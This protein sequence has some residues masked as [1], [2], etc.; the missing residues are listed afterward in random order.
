MKRW[1][2]EAKLL[3]DTVLSPTTAFEAVELRAP[4]GAPLLV[5]G[6]ATSLLLLVQG[7]VLEQ[8]VRL[9]PLS[10]ETPGGAEVAIRAF[11]IVRGAAALGAPFGLALRAAALASVLQ[12]TAM[13]LGARSAWRSLLSLCLHLEIVFCIESACLS[14]V[15]LLQPPASVEALESLRLH[16]GLDLVWQPASQ[17]VRALLESANAFTVWW[18]VLLALGLVRLLRVRVR[19]ALGLAAPFWGAVVALRYLV[20]PH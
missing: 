6:G 3:A 13:L 9:D 8:V 18:A 16:A 5:V 10:A 11:W 4:I 14:L 20:L 12:A 15:L 1:L 17:S 7:F 2:H 19:A